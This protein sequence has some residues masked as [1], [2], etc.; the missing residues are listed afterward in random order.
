MNETQQQSLRVVRR[1]GS[2]VP[3]DRQRISNAIASAILRDAD[4]MPRHQAGNDLMPAERAK[5]ERF[6]EQ[7]VAAVSRRTDADEH[8][9]C[10][11]DIQDQV[12]LA[13]MRDG[14]HA[15]ARDYVLYRERRR[16]EREVQH[17]NATSELGC[18]GAAGCEACQ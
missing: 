5:V 14:E 18:E 15:I 6:T 7:V 1:D 17:R 16:V 8:P 13:L 4:G 2:V 9:I 3:F 11:E 12:E 10:I